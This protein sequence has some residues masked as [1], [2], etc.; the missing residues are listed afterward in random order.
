[1]E[2]DGSKG[3]HLVARWCLVDGLEL[4]RAFPNSSIIYRESS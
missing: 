3:T 1:M 4:E 2:D